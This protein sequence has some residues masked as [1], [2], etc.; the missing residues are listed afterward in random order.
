MQ[1]LSYVQYSRV[2]RRTAHVLLVARSAYSS[3]LKA[4]VLRPFKMNV[5][6]HQAT[7]RHIRE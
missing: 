7:R 3:T 4:K 2:R 1:I 5:N 6:F